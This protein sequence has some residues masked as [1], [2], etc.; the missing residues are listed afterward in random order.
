MALMARIHGEEIT[1]AASWPARDFGAGR[2]TTDRWAP[3]VSEREREERVVPLLAC[4]RATEGRARGEKKGL[5][6]AEVVLALFHF[7]CKNS[8]L[9]LKS[10]IPITFEIFTQMDSNQFV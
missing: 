10:E 3:P 9:F 7:F 8:F 5:R 4:C 1:A 6:W 2:E